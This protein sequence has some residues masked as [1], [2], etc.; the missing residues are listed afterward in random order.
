MITELRLS[1]FRG[2]EQTRIEIAPITLFTGANNV[3]KSTLLYALLTLKNIVT[4]P[5]QPLDSFFNLQF[6]NLGGFK[7]TVHLKEEESRKIELEIVSAG[8]A[9][10]SRY[11]VSLGRAQSSI[12]LLQLKPA[13]FR[14]RLDV[15]FPY[16]VNQQT[17]VALEEEFESTKVSW[18]GITGAVTAEQ[19]G[20]E[21]IIGRIAVAVGAPVEDI[22]QIDFVP[23]KRGFVKPVFSPVPL[24]AQLITEDEIATVLAN[25][26]D[27]EGALN[28]CLERIVN[29]SFRARPILGTSS[30]HLH[31][32]DR[33]SGFVCD[34]VNDGFG[35]NQ[36]VYLLTKSLR[37]GQSTVCIEEPEIHLH[38]SALSRLLEVLIE[39]AKEKGRRFILSTHSEHFVTS[40]LNK[41]AAKA[42][43]PNDVRL[44]YLRKERSRTIVEPQRVNEK[45]Q[46]EGGLKG[47]YEA[48]LEQIRQFLAIESAP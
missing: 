10:E 4:N 7:E 29:K 35:T 43:T 20:Q 21:E 18:N 45:G 27:L 26:P 44:Y 5:N 25:D 1:N 36:L 46:I 19:A 47:F 37:K 23:L 38:P 9:G 16:A 11:G 31:T 3:G 22:K 12:S 2:I 24:Q 33:T 17:G 15:T 6:L 30:F 32:I 13:N 14:L 48:E 28:S 8:E 42:L 39:V 40:L 34:L 41:V